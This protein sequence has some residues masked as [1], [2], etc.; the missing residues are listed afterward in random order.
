M[1]SI[2]DNGITDNSSGVYEIPTVTVNNYKTVMP[3]TGS[4]GDYAIYFFAGLSLIGSF[5]FYKKRR[6]DDEV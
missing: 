5:L 4:V 2:K 3:A 1:Q 6:K